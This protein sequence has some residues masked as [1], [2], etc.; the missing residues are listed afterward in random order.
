[1]NKRLDKQH[2]NANMTLLKWLALLGIV[3]I[4]AYVLLRQFAA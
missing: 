1:M 2:G 3:G 4:A